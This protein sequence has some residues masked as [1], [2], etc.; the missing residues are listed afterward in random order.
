[1][2]SPN[3]FDG[4]EDAT[5]HKAK[6]LFL[7]HLE[8]VDTSEGS[9]NTLVLKF[10]LDPDVEAELQRFV[11]DHGCSCVSLSLLPRLLPQTRV[12]IAPRMESRVL[13][14]EEQ[15]KIDKRRKNCAQ[16]TWFLVTPEAQ[17]EYLKNGKSV[18]PLKRPTP[19]KATAARSTPSKTPRKPKTQKAAS[20][21][22]KEVA[23]T[24]EVSAKG[25]DTA[26]DED[27]TIPREKLAG[28]VAR[29]ADAMLLLPVDAPAVECRDALF[30]VAREMRELL[31]L[32]RPREDDD[33]AGGTSPKKAKRPRA[34][35]A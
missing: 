8:E 13:S 2:S 22:K 7:K 29:L 18:S 12:I 1:M 27:L 3:R 11:T 20:P 16:H 15:D 32:K 25:S 6:Q 4:E 33:E 23:P 26:A 21:V 5:L 17:E 19:K 24:P 10:L 9:A 30:E 14:R 28:I 31:P 35:R 34:S